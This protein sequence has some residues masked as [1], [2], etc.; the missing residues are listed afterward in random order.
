[1]DFILK[2]PKNQRCHDNILVVMDRLIKQ[3]HFI[4]WPL[5]QRWWPWKWLNYVCKKFL[6]CK[7]CLRKSF[8]TKITNVWANF[9]VFF[10][11][12][13]DTK[14]KLSNA[15]HLEIEVQMERTNKTLEDMLKAYVGNKQGKWEQFLLLVEFASM[16]V[17]TLPLTWFHFMPYMDRNAKVHFCFFL[18]WNGWKRWLQKCNSLKLIKENMQS[19]EGHAKFYVDENRTLQEFLEVND[20]VFLKVKLKCSGLSLGKC[21]KLSLRFCDPFTIRKKIGKMAYQL[22]LPNN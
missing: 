8:V 21:S 1:M 13:L 10:F 3:T 19:V 11:K 5:N 2:L 18:K 4:S 14:L 20:Q 7:V 6:G 9:K 22:D 17:H 12:M 15:Y 16:G